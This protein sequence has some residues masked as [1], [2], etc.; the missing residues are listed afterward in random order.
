MIQLHHVLSQPEFKTVEPHTRVERI[1]TLRT[2]GH[3]RDLAVRFKRGELALT[4]IV[5]P[6]RSFHPRDQLT[7]FVSIFDHEKPT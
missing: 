4:Q 5:A 3:P 7:P 1:C 2:F 6:R